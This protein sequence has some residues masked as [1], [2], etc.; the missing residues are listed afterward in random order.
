MSVQLVDVTYKTLWNIAGPVKDSTIQVLPYLYDM[1]KI[2]KDMKKPCLAAPQVGIGHRFFIWG[3]KLVF[4]NPKIKP[5][6]DR[7][8]ESVLE[9]CLSSPKDR[10]FVTRFS[11]IN[12]LWEDEF[13]YKYYKKLSGEFATVFQHCFDHLQ[14]KCVFANPNFK[15]LALPEH[16]E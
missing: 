8:I 15:P 12:A 7:A 6:E 9:C 14:G 11:S 16:H 4:V 10:V 1:R 13:G 3:E 2:L 5:S